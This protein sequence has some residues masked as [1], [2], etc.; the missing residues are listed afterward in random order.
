MAIDQGV[1][2]MQAAQQYGA[3]L[4]SEQRGEAQQEVA[5]FVRWCGRDR[6]VQKLTPAE[7]AQYGEWVAQES[8]DPTIRITPVRAFLTFLKKSDL[9]SVGLVSHLRVPKGKRPRRIA[10]AKGANALVE[11]TPEGHAKLR[12]RLVTL[13][14]ERVK[15]VADIQRAMADKDFKENSPL[16]A[17]KERQGQIEAN[18]RELEETLQRAVV[19]QP[20]QVAS[21]TPIKLGHTV[22]LKELDSGKVS[23]YIL[24]D[25]AEADPRSGK[26][27][28]ISPVGR[29]LLQKFAGD[30]VRVSVPRG[31]VSYRILTSKG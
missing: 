25:P 9:V 24:V 11:L 12:A 23:K 22:S 19:R 3:T 13:K 29:A 6:A 26:I 16:D 18:V 2:L 14:E 7:V 21:Y 10:S 8:T 20:G 27:S 4:A 1:S 30:E 17:A 28:V 31:T 5:R 15:T